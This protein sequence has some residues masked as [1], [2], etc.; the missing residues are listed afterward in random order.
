MKLASVAK[1]LVSKSAV[2]LGSTAARVTVPGLSPWKVNVPR[3]TRPWAS[4][5]TPLVSALRSLRVALVGLPAGLRPGAPNDQGGT[6]GAMSAVARTA[7]TPAGVL[8]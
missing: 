4:G 3:S 5:G 2:G 7:A 8:K 1:L 6:A